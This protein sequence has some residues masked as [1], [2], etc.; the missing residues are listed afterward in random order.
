M[1]TGID[2]KENPEKKII[3][4]YQYNWFDINQLLFYY[5]ND[6]SWQEN[7]ND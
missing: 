3:L 5:V 7:A 6:E 4:S 2:K 1:E